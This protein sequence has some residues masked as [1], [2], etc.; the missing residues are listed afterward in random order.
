MYLFINVRKR[1]KKD[2]KRQE[3]GREKEFRRQAKK[4]ILGWGRWMGRTFLAA[5]A[6]TRKYDIRRFGV[7]GRGYVS[8]TTVEA[9]IRLGNPI[10]Q[11][12]PFTYWDTF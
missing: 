7:P 5:R 6:V 4:A 10:L 11:Y 2:N 12:F 9:A 1:T 8:V 3:K